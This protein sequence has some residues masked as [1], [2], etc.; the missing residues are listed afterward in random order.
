MRRYILAPAAQ[1]DLAAIRDYYLNEAGYR[2][3]RQ[4]LVEFG[5]AFRAI[6]RNPRIGHR[7]E[8][9]AADRPILFWPMRDFLII[10]RSSTEVIEIVTIARASRDIAVIL[11]RRD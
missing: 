6:A 7:R 9:L 3:A 11:K 8:D 4:M 10:Y 2:I 5:N 1:E